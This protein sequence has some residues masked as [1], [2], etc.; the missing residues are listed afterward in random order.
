MEISGEFHKQSTLI[1]IL[2]PA[3]HVPGAV[4][5]LDPVL[6]QWPPVS[7]Q[8]LIFDLVVES[9]HLSDFEGAG[10]GGRP[11]YNFVTFNFTH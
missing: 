5:L 3:K 10:A 11:D 6:A 9:R 1:K 7:R 8:R 4:E 2:L